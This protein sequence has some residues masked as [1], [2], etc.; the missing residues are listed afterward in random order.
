MKVINKKKLLLYIVFIIILY[1]AGS[2]I[3]S[4][5][6]T[7]VHI[8]KVNS[9]PKE[10]SIK[11]K[12]FIEEVKPSFVFINSIQ[13]D[14]YVYKYSFCYL[15]S[16]GVFQIF[17]HR[18]T[19]AN[20]CYYKFMI[21]DSLKELSEIGVQYNDLETN[22]FNDV[23]GYNAFEGEEILVTVSRDDKVIYKALYK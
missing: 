13:D 2:L 3:V 9:V 16:Y 10:E 18:V 21:S 23:D 5:S 6:S 17:K 11:N 22:L 19:V 8:G 15:K 14:F 7:F 20:Q 1:I 4:P 12:T